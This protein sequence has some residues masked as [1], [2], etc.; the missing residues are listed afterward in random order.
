MRVKGA[1][2]IE[3]EIRRPVKS[4]PL[5]TYPDLHGIVRDIK[6][7]LDIGAGVFT[8]AETALDLELP[9]TAAL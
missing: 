9:V 1:I 3:I 7:E 5:V 8:C 4:L 2:R 6:L